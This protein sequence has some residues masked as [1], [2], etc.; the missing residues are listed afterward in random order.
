MVVYAAVKDG[1][2]NVNLPRI[3]DI[4][5]LPTIHAPRHQP[6]RSQLRWQCS[7]TLVNC[8]VSKHARTDNIQLAYC[9]YQGTMPSTVV[10]TFTFASQESL[11]V[12]V[13]LDFLVA[14]M[15]RCLR[16]LS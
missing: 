10:H 14:I 2:S 9:Y 5:D 3:S 16:Y 7:G 8:I 13:I 4:P 15:K 1:C 11:V 6:N 12:K